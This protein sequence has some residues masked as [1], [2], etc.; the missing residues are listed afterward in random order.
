MTVF[1]RQNFSGVSMRAA[2]E[3]CEAAELEITVKP[4]SLKP[5][6]VRALA[7]SI[8]RRKGSKWKSD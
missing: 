3:L 8:P 1:L 7:R 2:K 4:K 6:D 5:D